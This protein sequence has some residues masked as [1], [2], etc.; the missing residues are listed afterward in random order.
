ME[1]QRLVVNLLWWKNKRRKRKDQKTSKSACYFRLST[2][3]YTLLSILIHS[4]L[5]ISLIADVSFACGPGRGGIRRRGPRK[6]T[7]LVYRQ[8]IPNFSERSLA[9]RSPPSC[10]T[11]AGCSASTSSPFLIWKST[12]VENLASLDLHERDHLPGGHQPP[13]PALQLGHHDR[14]AIRLVPTPI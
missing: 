2:T 6:L 14:V 5:A 4:F 7:P 8:H 9:A 10:T 3:K 12:S 13:A 1:I 11:I